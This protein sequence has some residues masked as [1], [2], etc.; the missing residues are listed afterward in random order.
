VT[1]FGEKDTK[2]ITESHSNGVSYFQVAQVF[3]CVCV[4]V[5]VCVCGMVTLDAKIAIS[6]FQYPYANT[7]LERSSNFHYST[8]L[9]PLS[10]CILLNQTFFS[11]IAFS[12][13][14]DYAFGYLS[15]ATTHFAQTDV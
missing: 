15:F 4:C 2:K 12:G 7:N 13:Y 8:K 14:D 9:L 6:V 5:C 10:P 1:I 3:L 11:R